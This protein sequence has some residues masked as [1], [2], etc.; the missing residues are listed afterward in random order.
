[1]LFTYRQPAEQLC[2][3]L[4]DSRLNSCDVPE[5]TWDEDEHAED[6]IFTK[7]TE[8][9]LVWAKMAGYPFW[10]AMIEVDPDF[11][12]FCDCRD[13]KNTVVRDD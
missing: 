3:F 5:E 1:M 10:P 6:Y 7:F 4:T 9:S 13:T 12:T 8:G 11:Q 2:Y